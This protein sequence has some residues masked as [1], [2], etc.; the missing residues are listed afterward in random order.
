MKPT[1]IIHSSWSPIFHLL[2]ESPL[3]DLNEAILPII[4]YQP[5]NMHIFR[6]LSMPVNK[7]KVILL[8]QDPYPTPGDAIG[9]SFVNGTERV[10]ASLR[11]ITKEI[12]SST[13][14]GA[15]DIHSWEKQ[16][17]FLLNT[18]LTVETGKPGSHLNYWE[19]FTKG[20]IEYLSNENPAIWILWGKSAQQ[21]KK[22]I[23]QPFLIG[24]YPDE[25]L[26][27][28]P[29]KEDCNYILEAPHPA[30]ETYSGGKA[31]FYGCNHFN[32]VNHILKSKGLDEIDW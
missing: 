15:V 23:K 26:E 22:F 8:G 9:L 32:M 6:A 29:I 18:A 28:I 11:I 25:L 10:P 1:D 27:E 16:G 31:G 20:V 12:L 4:S 21:Y 13:G 30:S 24:N 2:Y 7:V 3:K 5:H 17:I 19:K 14:K